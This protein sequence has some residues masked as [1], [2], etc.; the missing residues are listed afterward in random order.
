MKTGFCS[1]P[2]PVSAIYSRT[3][4]LDEKETHYN[5]REESCREDCPIRAIPA[6]MTEKKLIT[7]V[8]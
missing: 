6:T 5:P 7:V 2:I 1:T 8:T 4:E 3:E